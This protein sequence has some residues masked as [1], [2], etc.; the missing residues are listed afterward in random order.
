MKK[1][2]LSAVCALVLVFSSAAALPEGFAKL[3]SAITARAEDGTYYI[4]ADT[5]YIDDYFIFGE[6]D[7]TKIVVDEANETYA[8]YDGMLFS[9]DMKTL[10]KCPE[11]REGEVVIPDGV[12]EIGNMKSFLGP[13]EDCNSI[14]KITLPDSVT[15]IHDRSFRYCKSLKSFNIPQNAKMQEFAYKACPDLTRCDS[16]DEIIVDERNTNFEDVDGTIYSFEK[17]ADNTTYKN[18]FFK[19]NNGKKLHITADCDEIVYNY[20]WG[21]GVDVFSYIP[22]DIIDDREGYQVIGDGYY[23]SGENGLSLVAY[24]SGAKTIE[25]ADGVTYIDAGKS[26]L[27]NNNYTVETIILPDSVTKIDDF[28]FDNCGSLK[29]VTIPSSVTSISNNS[30][31]YCD[32]DE[33]TIYCYKDS[34]AHKFA[35]DQGIK[36][37]LLDGDNRKKGD[38]NDNGK[39][40]ASDLLQVKSH[41]KK[42][43]PLEGDDFTCA[44]VDGNGAIN[45]ADLL[46]MKAHMK[47]VSSIWE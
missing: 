37:K 17:K 2:I 29:S 45:A 23:Y 31:R 6:K 33:L 24:K 20:Y 19:N 4:S 36:Y 30:F 22:D 32:Y 3:D 39:I 16:L 14:T 21:T 1:K 15:T 34:A 41:I 35:V 12:E 7:I 42:V 13:F 9:K 27:L 28:A 40:D 5:T 38:L 11:G 44:D 25:L 8:S 10:I 47:G 43:K 46:K 18:L 26:S